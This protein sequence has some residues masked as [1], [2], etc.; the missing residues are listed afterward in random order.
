M[1]KIISLVLALVMVVGLGITA[2]AE[3]TATDG[4]SG[5]VKAVYNPSSSVGG[6]VYSV[7]ISWNNLEFTY[8]EGSEPTWNA[9]T[10]KYEGISEPAEW[11][12]EGDEVI[13]VTNHSNTHIKAIPSYQAA[14]G[15]E[16][17]TMDFGL[18][19]LLVPSAALKNQAQS[20]SF[21]VVP[22]GEL[23]EDTEELT[24]IGTITLTISEYELTL[25]EQT[26]KNNIL[27]GCSRAAEEELPVSDEMG[28]LQRFT[29]NSTIEELTI[30][31]FRAYNLMGGIF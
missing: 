7:D 3:I 29:S 6:T 10:H 15:F 4:N 31:W 19:E 28:E 8:N 13:T 20:E 22:S 16:A 30:A 9:E 12:I 11:V 23:P 21:N 24:T 2:F 27:D 1:K 18:T 17:I 14:E 26:M 25:D 5:D